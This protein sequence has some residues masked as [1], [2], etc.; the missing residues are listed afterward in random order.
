MYTDLRTSIH[1][2]VQKKSSVETWIKRKVVLFL[3]G[4]N[5]VL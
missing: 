4:E 2:A 5:S 1:F 3:L